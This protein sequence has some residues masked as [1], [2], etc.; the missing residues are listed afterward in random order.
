M[1]AQCFK[2]AASYAAAR[3]VFY[4]IRGHTNETDA[5][6][7]QKNDPQKK[8]TLVLLKPSMPREQTRAEREQHNDGQGEIVTHAVCL[9]PNPPTPIIRRA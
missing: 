3:P 2:M 4:D 6:S 9:F 5:G 8:G 1:V 7:E